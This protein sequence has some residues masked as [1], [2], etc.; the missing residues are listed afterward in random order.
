MKLETFG[1]NV[2]RGIKIHIF[3]NEISRNIT[4]PSPKKNKEKG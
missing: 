3:K 4:I 2:G 1:L